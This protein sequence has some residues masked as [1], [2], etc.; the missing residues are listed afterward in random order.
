M[1]YLCIALGVLAVLAGLWAQSGRIALSGAIMLLWCIA[2]NFVVERLGFDHAPMLLPE[3]TAE[4]MVL[5]V[6][7]ALETRSRMGA[8][9][10]LGC[11]ADIVTQTW[12]FVNHAQGTWAY[13]AALNVIY[14]VLTLGVGIT[15]V[16]LGLAH[17]VVR[18]RGLSG[19]H[20]G[21]GTHSA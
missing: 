20:F 17:G 19:A 18:L 16:R 6:A 3:I 5:A 15:G 1:G 13:Y 8:V 9:V 2:S 7:L 10:A 12:F 11:I 14:L 21:G 4:M